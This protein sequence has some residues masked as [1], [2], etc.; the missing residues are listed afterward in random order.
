MEEGEKSGDVAEEEFDTAGDLRSRWREFIGSSG[1]LD[2]GRRS[3]LLTVR[4]ST[5]RGGSLGQRR[6]DDGGRCGKGGGFLRLSRVEASGG[7]SVLA[8]KATKNVSQS[9]PQQEE[10][11][12]KREGRTATALQRFSPTPT[13][14]AVPNP[15]SISKSQDPSGP[16]R[17]R[18]VEGVELRGADRGGEEGGGGAGGAGGVG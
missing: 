4:R 5:G 2:R 8:G 7:C 12:R 13:P 17:S 6:A 1:S 15:P 3:T 11:G 10:G 18:K 14:A 9:R 16:L